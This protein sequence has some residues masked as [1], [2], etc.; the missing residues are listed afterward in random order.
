M[1]REE[2]ALKLY[3]EYQHQ[4]DTE[5]RKRYLFLQN[6]SIQIAL[7]AVCRKMSNMPL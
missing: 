4:A 3:N 1:K 7:Y 2:K 5:E 6:V